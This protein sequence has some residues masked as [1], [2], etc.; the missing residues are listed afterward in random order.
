MAAQASLALVLLEAVSGT[1]TTYRNP[2]GLQPM[3]LILPDRHH[4]MEK[5]DVL[6]FPDPGKAQPY[7][8][9]LWDLGCL[10]KLL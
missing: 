7:Q 6:E 4:H 10:S 5:Q 2:K 3:K 8:T 9:C 1:P